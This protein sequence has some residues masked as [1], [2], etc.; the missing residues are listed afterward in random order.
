MKKLILILLILAGFSSCKKSTE[1]EYPLKVV[2]YNHYSS[3]GSDMSWFRCDSVQMV[4]NKEAFIWRDGVR[5]KIIAKE[6]I[7]IYD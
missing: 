6:S 3:W 4:T 5:M 7:K 1:K 2:I